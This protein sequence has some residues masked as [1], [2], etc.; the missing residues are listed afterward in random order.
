MVLKSISDIQFTDVSDNWAKNY[1]YHL[2]ARGVVNNTANFNPDNN[3]TRAE[4]LKIIVNAAGLGKFATGTTSSF[5]DV[6]ADSW[7]A[8][9][10]SFAVSKGIISKN[11]QFRPNDTITRAEIAKILVNVLGADT[12]NTQTTFTDTDPASDLTKYI[13]TAQSLG[14]FSGQM[15]DGQLRFRPN[16]SITRAEIAK[17]VVKAFKL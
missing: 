17:V 4:A 6:S 14:I 11:A 5:S 1:I 9:Y 12:R 3:L 8:P 2:V 16:D 7:Y 15:I 13:A 10:V